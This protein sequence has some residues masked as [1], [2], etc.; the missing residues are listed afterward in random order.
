MAGIE[1]SITR[2]NNS[3]L[4]YKA[5]LEA[6]SGIREAIDHYANSPHL[7]RLLQTLLPVLNNVLQGPPS[8]QSGSVEQRLRHTVLDT[9]TRLPSSSASTEGL[10]ALLNQTID[11]LM[12]QIRVD[13]EENAILCVKIVADIMRNPAKI[14]VAKVQPFLSL[15]QEIFNQIGK[16][17][18]EQLDNSPANGA[19][20]APATT[21]NPQTSFQ[22]PRPDSP[23]AS[24]ND[25]GPDPQQQNRLLV[26]G[27]QSFKVLSE[28]PII[29]VAIFSTYRQIVPANVK[30]FIPAT[31]AVLNQEAAAQHQAHAQA[32][33]KGQIFTGVSPAIKNRAA[34]G[35]LIG[36][37]AKTLT[38]LVFL[39]RQ[40]HK[41]MADVTKTLPTIIV[42]LLRD[43]PREKSGT[44]KELL[45]ALRHMIHFNF[46]AFFLP[47]IN[48]LLDEE[49]LI[50][51][52]LA[53][54]ETIRPLAYSMLAD[55]IHN[56]REQLKP[57]QI[58]K[59]VGVYTKNLQNP[60]PGTSF[61][62]M[63]AR[64]LI[65]MVDSIAKME[66]KEDARYYLMVI[67]E[68]FAEKFAD[69][70]HQYPNAVKRSKALANVPQEAV[71]THLAEKEHIPE[72]DEVDI[73]SAI[74]IR[75]AGPL[76]RTGD[77]V[78]E[79][80]FLFQ[81]M[82]HGLKRIF[83]QLRVCNPTTPAVDMTNAPPNWQDF[84]CGFS[85]EE[86]G[87]MIKTFRQGAQVFKYYDVESPQQQETQ[88]SSTA[89]YMANTYMNSSSKEEK[90]LIES[91]A[92]LFHAVDPSTFHEI[93]QE[94]IPHL[95]ELIFDHPALL[96]IPQ[97]FLASEATSPS[98]CGM[99]LRFLMD[100]ISEVGTADIKKSSILLRLFKLAFMAV[101][102]F[103]NQNEQI[104]L[105]HVVDIVTKSIDLSTKAEE[106]MN[107]FLLLR[108]LF[109]SIGGGKF[110]HLYK[111]ILPLLEMLLEVLNNL[112]LAARRMPER[113]LYVELCLTVPARLSN[114]LPYLS[115]LMRPLVVALRSGPE[116]VSQGLRTLE[117]CVDNLTA[118][119]LDPILLPVMDD[120][121][122]AL[123]DHLRP[124]PY[125][126]FHS[127]TTLRILGKLGGRNRKSMVLRNPLKFETFASD[128]ASFD[129]RLVGSKKD[130]AFPVELG[131]DLAIEKLTELPRTNNKSTTNSSKGQS[132]GHYKKLALKFVIAQ[133]KL[134]IGFENLPDDFPRLLRLQAYDMTQ[135]ADQFNFSAFAVP[136]RDRSI[137]KRDGQNKVLQKLLKA[138]MSAMAVPEL[139]DEARTF[140]LNICRHFTITEFGRA[141]VDAKRVKALFDPKAGEGP[142]YIDS[143]VLADAA[144]E[145]LASDHPD[146]RDAGKLAIR[147]V[148][149]AATI[150]L[151]TEKD[152]AMVPFFGYLSGVLMHSCY[153]EEWFTKNG[154][155]VGIRFL[156]T[157]LDLGDTWLTPKQ[158]IEFIRALM[159]VVKDMPQDLPEKTRSSAQVALDILLQ[160]I[161]KDIKKEDVLPIRPSVAPSQPPT[162]A[163]GQSPA[164]NQTSQSGQPG[165]AQP[166][167]STPAQAQQAQQKPARQQSKMFQICA[168]FN[169]DLSHMNR[170]V[171]ETAKKLLE[172]I[173]KAADCE[174]WDLVEP[175]KDRLLQTVYAK[176]LRA[177]PFATQIGYIDAVTYHMNLNRQWVVFDEPL[178]RL[179]ME[180]LALADAPDDSLANK[181]SEYRTRENIVNLR[182]SCLKL[183]SSAMSFDEFAK[184][185]TNTTRTKIVTTFFKCLYSDNAKT[186]EAG[187][188]ALRGVLTPTQ[189]LPKELL[190]IGL[191]PVLTNLQDHKKLTPHCL[192]NLARL[193]K[194][195]TNYFKVEIGSRL[196]DHVKTL[197]DPLTVNKLSFT[198]FEQSPVIRVISLLFNIF[199]LLPPEAEKFKEKLVETFL[200]LEA[201]LRRTRST[202]FREP[203][204]KYFNRYP[205][206]LW[207]L[208]LAKLDDHRY[209]I[210]FSQALKDPTCENL[211]EAAN[212]D[213]D[214]LLKRSNDII[215]QA[216]DTKFTVMVNALYVLEALS[217]RPGA[218]TWLQRSEVTTWVRNVAAQLEQGLS[219]KSV[220]GTG[221][222]LLSNLRI[223]AARASQA[224]ITILLNSLKHMPRNLDPL[225][226]V[227][228]ATMVK[229]L[230][231]SPRLV[232][233]IYQS[234]IC[235]TDVEF[236]RET[237]L[238]CLEAYS[239]KTVSQR[240]KKFVL[241]NIVN[242]IFA[243]NI[244]RNWNSSTP[245]T[246]KPLLDSSVMDA[247]NTR[248]WKVHP[249]TASDDSSPEIDHT[250]LEIL[251]LSALLIKYHHEAFQDSRKEIIKF[252]WTFIRLD[253]VVIKHA[254]YVVIAYFIALYETPP[255]IIMQIYCSLLRLKDNEGRALVFQGLDLIAPVLPKYCGNPAQDRT[256]QWAIAPRR[257]LLD[258]GHSNGQ[259]MQNIFHFLVKHPDL[260]Y[261]AREKHAV[262]VISSI[263]K[264]IPNAG[265][266]S[267]SRK[268]ALNM[269]W[270]IWE[271]EKRR[272]EGASQ[273]FTKSPSASPMSRKRKL[274]DAEGGTAESPA[275]AV[276]T[277]AVAASGTAMP[278]TEFQIPAAF[279]LRMIK[280]LVEFIAQLNT[281]RYPVTSTKAKEPLPTTLA[282][283]HPDLSRRAFTLLYNLLQP[284]YWG[285]LELDLFGNVPEL[286]L[287]SDKAAAVL[288]ADIND[289]DVKIDE[290][291]LCGIVNMLQVLRIVANSQ[292]DEWVQRNL[293]QLLKLLDR[294][295]KSEN[296]EVQDCL[297]GADPKCD[298]GRKIKPLMLRF[299]EVSPEDVAME[300]ADADADAEVPMSETVS[301]L[302][303]LATEAMASGNYMAGV[304]LLWSLGQW[305]KSTIDNHIPALMKALQSRLA[306]EHVQHYQ[307]VA[308][309]QAN[310]TANNSSANG[311]NPANAS[312]AD[313]MT[314][315]RLELQTKLM[316]KAI[317][318]VALRMEILQDHRRP[319]LSVLATLVEKSQHMELCEAILAMAET[320]VFRSDAIWP[321]LKEK[322]AVLHKMLAFEQRADPTL[323]NRFLELV[324]RIYEDPRIARTELTVR[325]EQAFLVGTRAQDA[326]L[327]DRFMAIFDKS[328]SKTAATRL[329]YVISGQSWDSLADSFWLSQ[330]SQL[331]LA[332]IE[333]HHTIQLQNDDFRTLPITLLLST[334]ASGDPHREP[335]MMPDD[336]YDNFMA[337]HRTF[338][339]ELTDVKV[340]DILE[341]LAQLQ[342]TDSNISHQ[343]WVRLFP[344]FWSVVSRDD[345]AELQKALVVLLTKEYHSRQLDRRPNVVQSLVDGAAKAW[346]E[347]KLPPH[348]LKFVARTYG[349]WY[350]ALIQMEQA[351]IKPDTESAT[352]RES[353]LDALTELYAGLQEDDL[354]YGAWRRRCQ[355]VETNAALSYQ[356]SG[357]WDKA[358]KMYEAAQIRARTGVV[359]YK[360]AE[361]M[362]W[363]DEWVRCAMKL[364]QWEILQE[365]AKHEN[366]QDLL[367]EC[368][369][370][371]T[372]MWQASEHREAL[373]N[374]LKGM[375]DAPTPRRMYFQS[376]MT[377]LKLHHDSITIQASNAQAALPQPSQQPQANG[378]A[379]SPA[380]TVSTPQ[381]Q[382]QPLPILTSADFSKL[383][384]ESIQLTIR[385]WHQLPNSFTGAHVSLLHNFQLLVE[386]HD[387]SVI[388]QSLVATTQSNLDVKSGELKL[389]LGAWRDRLPN[390]WDDIQSWQELVSWR[391][392]I[393]VLINQTYLKLAPQN[394]PNTSNTSY[395]YR[396]YHETAWI[397][398]RF[399]HVSRKHGLSDVCINQLSRIYTLPNIEIQEAFLKLRE[400][401]KCHFEN[402][403]ELKAGLEVI[404]NT[405]LNY[406]TPAQKAE[407]YTLKGMF[408]ERLSE[409]DEADQAYGTALWFDITAAKAWAEWGRF[410]D[411]KFKADPTN[412]NLGRLALI[413][414]L[415]AAASFKNAK[416]RKLVARI[417]WLLSLDDAK[418]QISG[419]FDEYKSDIPVWYWITFIP[420]LLGGLYHKEAP[421]LQPILI[422]IAKSYPQALYFHLRT[423]RDDVMALRK[424]HEQRLARLR[425]QQAQNNGAATNPAD[426]S[427]PGK[428]HVWEYLDE[429][430]AVLKTAFPLLALSMETMVDQIQKQFK[431]PLDEDA[432]RL[433]VALLNDGLAYVSRMPHSFGKD[434][435][436]PAATET[437]ITRF[438]DTILP[439]HI[440]ASFEEDFVKVKPTMYEYIQRLR[441]WRNK[442]EE[443]L[444]RRVLTVPLESFSPHLSEFSYQRFDDVEMPG[445]YLQHKDKNQDFIRIQRFLPNVDLIRGVSA[446]YRRLKIRGHDGSVHSWAVQHPAARHCRREEKTCQLFRGLNEALASK[447]ETRRRDLKFTLPWMVPLA[448]HL[449]MVH[450][451]VSYIS[452]QAVF[453]SYCK[454]NGIPKDKPIL[455]M[456]ERLHALLDTKNGKPTQS[457]DQNMQARYQVFTAIQDELVPQHVVLDYFHTIYND[458]EQFFLFRK[459]FSYQLASLSFMTYVLSMHNRQP[460]KMHISRSTGNI[461]GSDLIPY[462]SSSKPFFH[463]PEPV[464]FR[465]T[466]NLQVLMGP[467]ATEGIFTSSMLSIARSLTEPAGSDLEHTLALFVRDEIIHWFSSHQRQPVGSAGAVAAGPGQLQ[468]TENQLRESVQL[469]SDAIVKKAAALACQSPTI[470]PAT[471]SV[472]DLVAKAV[473]PMQLALSDALWM[474]YL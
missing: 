65:N 196:L 293:S 203:V 241:H 171:R 158:T 35:D 178:M 419:G 108:S 332:S 1:E 118:D 29:V 317:H 321:T 93:F 27:M 6:A 295:L 7:P 207:S 18:R 24:V 370:R 426:L 165:Q 75:P 387:A 155:T 80:K 78:H 166:P 52:G 298:E 319:F 98:F 97:F 330:A 169:A 236:W 423:I 368:A 44:R 60:F 66:N 324:L 348:V 157:E 310:A 395:A 192:E 441:T 340:R 361:Y 197:A 263:R 359:P 40:Y 429:L 79:N 268:L 237:V 225:F 351:A 87:I 195:L 68:A 283:S 302:S 289:K 278:R 175:H 54:H 56:V 176:P 448:A 322:T 313:E 434:V 125:P 417:L 398:N 138:T 39:F 94:E 343:L 393:F 468:M 184:P 67:M 141:L 364:Q 335:G 447:K 231:S 96:H 92:T 83:Y 32:A 372:D 28:C 114:L 275:L 149:S 209:G 170:H 386:L 461:W 211:R 306:R 255:K 133:I 444:D 381:A 210:L 33:A 53:V 473:N 107:Y 252:G 232:H 396:G 445:Q 223:P 45:I 384:D 224:A 190:Q 365:Y 326:S 77:P 100:R 292:S 336:R 284:Q 72:W 90:D 43:C 397:I 412:L 198:L 179:L 382:P 414:Y 8:F 2:L 280:Q 328:L 408:L 200:D 401:A 286:L 442:F 106:P 186:I 131:V 291:V 194:L 316:L 59:A 41:D 352:V 205:K 111:Q 355:F 253:D 229:V 5:R 226:T 432:Y 159:Y 420:Q 22:S 150:I 254:A 42:R 9:L 48:D 123:F 281:E 267:E 342:H 26:K 19:N 216:K 103:A 374:I 167:T 145:A 181:F 354:F 290:K 413:S 212:K 189:K 282:H 95:Y 276:A 369:W 424:N 446:S 460:Q 390:P 30:T 325:M 250:R 3:D 161:T 269:M 356:Q 213:V 256:V 115:F 453:D 312:S 124:H 112:L 262:A 436:L 247:I 438:A 360:P 168:H 288:T 349:S 183:L 89:E 305:K 113:D 400:Q 415:H 347:C 187:S 463:N 377:L 14:A 221:S 202:P 160:R 471:Q 264:V 71:E 259:Q 470:L 246:G 391:Q 465:L 363:E 308:N 410:H 10:E 128:P 143:R 406:F 163:P 16:I 152:I 88:F 427:E 240:T 57:D 206:D 367:L 296:P 301:S 173:A 130:R 439:P 329:A 61:Q 220:V 162:P 137:A 47:H 307:A 418:G 271:W 50:G 430:V 353:N 73:F 172:L 63:S 101:T 467:L 127:H 21:M 346:P 409:K 266:S 34:F 17:V 242:P 12:A 31:K 109:R 421:R 146:V 333:S 58:R 49:T 345:R 248:I 309:H 425:A 121:M 13:N 215:A 76:D 244:M 191:R 129:V 443:K 116:L 294:S 273:D 139:K 405:N 36:A 341:P 136:D 193:L 407:F 350:T 331:L 469:N 402:P 55:L 304:N 311:T 102:L 85:P 457:G 235:S 46:H 251:Q 219:E 454:R 450:E 440:K 132:E 334:H 378:Q 274:D 318:T 199:H 260:F 148:Y 233:H 201:G 151:G 297:H 134:R 287:A 218:A 228:D 472:I 435:K 449:R 416:S 303:N 174:V 154:G 388:C 375:M 357:L 81:T 458:Y 437:N 208:C 117:L 337:S 104:L 371:A 474:A 299:L 389:L 37:Q 466:P 120:L 320:W 327:R 147:E 265:S 315:Y 62:S 135:N 234:I 338:V 452:L 258:E 119:Y 270:L 164:P 285:D 180:S 64:L 122:T 383:C 11:V 243:M 91:F 404:N 462:V 459:Q 238:K 339:S 185:P 373:E 257:V 51:D 403:E 279:R 105:P 140:L 69:M 464:P 25:L 455:V 142:L 227:I 70:N 380:P 15:I 230:P 86:V 323:L 379:A 261:E 314:P 411:A 110:E 182:V 38:F 4:D 431:C 82:M 249:D 428:R 20:N 272:V 358:Q 144:V 222:K 399:A 366:F 362:L 126:H 239:S 456:I 451:D 376:F 23:A 153:E 300:D 217:D 277:P 385:K 392:H 394:P 84:T 99:L 204:Y 422:K 344:L 188:E 177:L 74:P 245:Q 214:A 156:L 433:I